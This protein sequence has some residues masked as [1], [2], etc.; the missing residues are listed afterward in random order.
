[1]AKQTDSMMSKTYLDCYGSFAV[2]L[3]LAL[4]PFRVMAAEFKHAVTVLKMHVHVEV[5]REGLETVDETLVMRIE[6][7]D[8]VNVNAN[9]RIEFSPKMHR[10]EIVEA[11]TLD[12]E[13][14]RHDV[15]QDSIRIQENAVNASSPQFSDYQYK[16]VVFPKAD[17]GSILH[18]RH[19]KTT[20]RSLLPGQVFYRTT[21]NPRLVYEDVR[22]TAAYPTSLNL[23]VSARDM[24]GGKISDTSGMSLYRYEYSQPVGFE[25]EPAAVSTNDYAPY[26]GLSSYKNRIELGLD[27]QRHAAPRMAVTPDVQ[28]IAD[29]VTEGLSGRREQID[30]LYQWVVKNIRYVSVIVDRSGLIP[31]TTEDILKRRYGDCKDHVTLLGAL[32]KA[33]GIDSS[34][35]LI[36]LG[37]AYTLTELA[38]ISPFNHVILYVP[39]EDL[40][41]DSTAPTVRPGDLYLDIAGKPVVLTALGAIGRTPDFKPDTNIAQ[42]DVELTLNEEGRITGRAVERFKGA[43]EIKLR[44]WAVDAQSSSMES[45]VRETLAAN[46]ES[47]NGHYSMGDPYDLGKPFEIINEFELDPLTNVPGPAGWRIPVGLISSGVRDQLNL[48]LADTRRTPFICS[49]GTV[50]E[51]YQIRFPSNIQ[52]RAMPSNVRFEGKWLVYS[53][54]YARDGEVVR[55]ERKIIKRYGKSVCGADEWEEF[56]GF[57]AAIRRDLRS[58]FVY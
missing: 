7:K 22:F 14:R 50:I 44:D 57:Q 10:V 13:G 46:G 19:R 5:N 52:I 11:F 32:L 41:L 16:I 42:T 51:R 3:I 49:P 30:A 15:P 31:N 25:S 54:S 2:M 12:S 58:Q 6:R 33:K 9:R 43:A 8:A 34:P 18:L 45:N 1:M 55:V 4:L 35:A 28:A 20:F 36:N 26:F 40:Y 29:K 39:Q 38:V 17:V 23:H 24:E 48:R 56:K 47:G 27:Y 53:A 37:T 21:I